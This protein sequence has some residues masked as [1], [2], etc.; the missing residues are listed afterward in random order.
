MVTQIR[1]A[2]VGW[3]ITY[4]APDTKQKRKNSTL[5]FRCPHHHLPPR[6]PRRQP[7]ESLQTRGTLKKQISFIPRFVI[8]HSITA[9]LLVDTEDGKC[10]TLV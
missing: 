4:E 7:L 2:Q 6:C 10:A 5:L 8:N 9:S 1:D 3:K